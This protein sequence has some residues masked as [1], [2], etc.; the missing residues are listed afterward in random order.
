VEVIRCFPGTATGPG[1]RRHGRGGQ[2]GAQSRWQLLAVIAA[3]AAAA[4]ILVTAA[5]SL[6]AVISGQW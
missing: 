6:V 4:A 2:A 1:R 3:L 5:L